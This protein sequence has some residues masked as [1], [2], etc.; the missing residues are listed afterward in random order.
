[1][2]ER[3]EFNGRMATFA[4]IDDDFNPVPKENAPRIKVIFDDGGVMFL[5][6]QKRMR[7]D[8]LEEF[9]RPATTKGKR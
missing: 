7:G 6:L 1:M 2:I 3:R 8:T 5:T 4:Y 9:W